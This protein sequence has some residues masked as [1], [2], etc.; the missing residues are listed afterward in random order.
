MHKGL[1]KTAALLMAM[2]VGLGAFGAHVLKTYLDQSAL[3]IFETGVRYQFY[4]SISLLACGILYKDFTGKKLIWAARMFMI[5]ILLFCVSLYALALLLP[6]YKFIGAITP[7]G[8]L[9]FIVGW[10]LLFAAFS[11]K[12]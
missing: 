11:E 9:S 12:K 6:D 2:A 4:H 1:L 8:G 5:G 7:L 3:A 10:L